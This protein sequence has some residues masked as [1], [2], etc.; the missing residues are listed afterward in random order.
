LG[1]TIGGQHNHYRA[2]SSF[3]GAVDATGNAYAQ[4]DLTSDSKTEWLV[5]GQVSW[6]GRR[7]FSERLYHRSRAT[8]FGRV[9]SLDRNI[10]APN[11][12]DHDVFTRYKR[13]HRYGL[14][15][16]D[17]WGLQRCLGSAWW[18]RPTLA[19]NEDLNVFE[20]D[21]VSLELG[22]A[23]WLGDWQIASRYRRT[24]YDRDGDR[25]RDIDQQNVSFKGVLEHWSY[26]GR[27][28][29]MDFSMRHDLDRG[30]TSAAVG[31]TVYFTGGQ[32]YYHL[33]PI[34]TPFRKL[35]EQRYLD[36]ISSPDWIWN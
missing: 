7:D 36:Q 1:P 17:R 27:R 29:V 24:R 16:S 4:T 12:V 15:L 19:T 13:D 22:L 18:L 35:K 21:Y 8:V 33:P 30:R 34:R 31:L 10:Y 14:R 23:R 6:T 5:G 2:L 32:G 3:P 28:Y 20:P 9:L 25:S 26:S 11:V